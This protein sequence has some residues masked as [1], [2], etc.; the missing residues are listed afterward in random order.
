MTY[1][2]NRKKE[3]AALGAA[4]LAEALSDLATRSEKADEVVFRLL[5]SKKEKLKR[6][7]AKLAGLESR[8]HFISWRE[9][10][11]FASHLES[12]LNDLAEAV[13]DPKTGLVKANI[14]LPAVV[15]Y[16]ALLEANVA[17]AIS[18]YY[19]HGIRYLKELD[20]ISPQV[21]DW[22]NIPPHTDYFA[23]FK[24]T[25]ARKS[26]FWNQYDA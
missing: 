14:Y 5:S 21:K 26:S 8:D 22:K 6:F 13:D 7:K 18:K 20:K 23:D 19:R 10:S 12:L 3:L 11:N 25:H 16:R 4:K 2:K 1:G 17:K 9:S 24:E 15:I